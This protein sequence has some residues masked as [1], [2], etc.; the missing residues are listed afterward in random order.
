[1]NVTIATAALTAL[2]L[3]ALSIWVVDGRRRWQ[4]SLGEGGQPE[5]LARIRA[6]ANLAEYGPLTIILLFL[7]EQAL[8]SGWFVLLMATL[9]L[10]GR[11]AHPF[12][13]VRP[14]PNP[15]RIFG[16]VGTWIVMVSLALA[17]LAKLVWP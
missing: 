16:M 11:I 15:F 4:V 10:L 6:Q 8:G 1:M 9:F 7:A 13:M 14:A 17:L 5:L 3:T 12:G 2:L